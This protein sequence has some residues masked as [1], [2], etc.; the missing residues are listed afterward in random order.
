[1]TSPLKYILRRFAL[2]KNRSM[3]EHGIVPLADL[4]SAVVF[5]DRT[6]PEADAAEAAAKEFFGG[7]GIALTVLSPGQEQLNHAGYMR[8]AFRLPG[9]K[10]RG[11]DLFISLSCRDD[12]FASEFEARCSPARFKVGRIRLAGEI[13][14]LCVG[15]PE[16]GQADQA[17]VFETISEYLLKIK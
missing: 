15:L 12:D 14:D 17:A 9:G 5:I 7:R 11:E 16:G 13:F 8:R 2:K 6:A 10:P 3:A 4:H 1:M